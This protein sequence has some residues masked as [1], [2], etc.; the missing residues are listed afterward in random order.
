[1]IDFTTIPMTASTISPIRSEAGEKARV[2]L[3]GLNSKGVRRYPN[4]TS[5]PKSIPA[6]RNSIMVGYLCY[7]IDTER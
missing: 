6:I 1:M 5:T 4:E 7:G 2:T 3:F